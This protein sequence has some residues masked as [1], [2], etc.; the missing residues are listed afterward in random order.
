MLL[1]THAAGKQKETLK[2]AV[3][4]NRPVFCDRDTHQLLQNGAP[5]L[6]VQSPGLCSGGQLSQNPSRK[7]AHPHHHLGVLQET[8][9]VFQQVFIH[10]VRL[11]LLHLRYV[12]LKRRKGLYAFVLM[13]SNC[14]ADGIAKT[15]TELQMM[16]YWG[17]QSEAKWPFVALEIITV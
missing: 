14:T 3:W 9:D 7:V 15:A 8:E 13:K 16:R 2:E 11:E 12:V 5:E 4:M 10:Q 17:V 1:L 6:A